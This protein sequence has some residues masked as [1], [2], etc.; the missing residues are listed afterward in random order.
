MSSPLQLDAH[1]R[2]YCPK[3]NSRWKRQE[4]GI[5]SNCLL[6]AGAAAVDGSD[7]QC[8]ALSG[9]ST[10]ASAWMTVDL[11]YRASLAAIGVDLGSSDV[12]MLS[13]RVGDRPVVTGSHAAPHSF[14]SIGSAFCPHDSLAMR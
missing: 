2:E 7:T 9:S 4:I 3:T 11:G 1:P 12:N 6:A 13:L 10:S 8:A 14:A 5:L